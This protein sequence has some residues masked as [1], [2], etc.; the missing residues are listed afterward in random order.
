[1][2]PTSLPAAILLAVS[3]EAAATMYQCPG[4]DGAPLFTDRACSGG[5]PVITGNR[6]PVSWNHMDNGALR[7]TAVR[8]VL[9]RADRRLHRQ[10][11]AAG[12]RRTHLDRVRVKK[13]AA[14]RSARARRRELARAARSLRRAATRS[15]FRH[16]HGT[17]GVALPVAPDRSSR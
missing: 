13:D 15:V 4:S 10:K 3:V 8:A 17:T 11:A 16:C 14:C 9:E 6:A 1:M 7:S 12:A 2:S 5:R